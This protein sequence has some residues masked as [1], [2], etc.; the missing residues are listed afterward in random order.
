[1]VWLC[2]E[3]LNE[4]GKYIQKPTNEIE[5]QKPEAVPSDTIWYLIGPNELRIVQSDDKLIVTAE[6]ISKSNEEW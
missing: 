1:M 4:M 5:I 2:R 3:K 6:E